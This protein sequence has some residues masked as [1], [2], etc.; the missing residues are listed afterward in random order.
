[1]IFL[2]LN[3]YIQ[4]NNLNKFQKIIACYYINDHFLGFET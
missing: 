3:I 4:N 1:M 2:K